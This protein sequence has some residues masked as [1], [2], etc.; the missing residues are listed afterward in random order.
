M[1]PVRVAHLGDRPPDRQD[2]PE[3]VEQALSRAEKDPGDVLVFLPGKGEI[4]IFNRF[5][6]IFFQTLCSFIRLRIE[7]A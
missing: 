1:F 5:E 4:G 2:L 7:K 6:H 3:R